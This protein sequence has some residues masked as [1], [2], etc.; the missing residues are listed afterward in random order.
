MHINK[1]KTGGDTNDTR[2]VIEPFSPVHTKM[3][4]FL[5]EHV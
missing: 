1:G 2:N 3:I 5:T 4:T